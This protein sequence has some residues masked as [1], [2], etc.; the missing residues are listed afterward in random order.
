MTPRKNASKRPRARHW[1]WRLT[2]ALLQ[3]GLVLGLMGALV[4]SVMFWHLS[5]DLP[6]IAEVKEYRPPETTRILDRND[7]LLG[8]V[9]MERRTVV[10]MKSIPRVLVL[11]VLAAE[12]ADFYRHKGLDYPGIARAVGRDILEG[13][14]AQGASTITQQVVKL[15]LLS[16]ERTM[17][18]KVKELIL[19]R[20]LEQAL[21]KDEILYLYLNQINFGH[22]RYGVEEASRYYFGKHAAELTLAEASLIAGIPQSPAN[23]SPRKHPE[24]AR[25]RQ[26]FVLRQLEQKRDT[27]W[28]DLSAADIQT[29]RDTKVALAQRDPEAE[30]APEIVTYVRQFLKTLVG[31]QAFAQGGYTVHTSVDVE[32]QGAARRSLQRNLRDVDARHGYRLP[33][34]TPS[35]KSGAWKVKLKQVPTL[36][37]GGTYDAVVTSTDDATGVVHLD[38]GGHPSTL[39]ISDLARYNPEKLA[40][41]KGFPVGARLRVSVLTLDG[42]GT[43]ATVHAELG[44]EGA[45]V[46]I[47]PRNRDVLAVVGGYASETGW[48]R[49]MQAARQPGSTFKPI[50]YA[51]G[52]KKRLYTAASILVDAPAVYDQWAPQ[53]YET[54]NN[55]GA[56]RLRE[57]IAQSINL[58]AVRVIEALTP[59]EV[60]TFAKKLGISTPLDPSLPLAL[61]ASEVHPMELVNAYAVFA[62]GGRYA[63]PTI[64]TAIEDGDGKSVKLPPAAATRTVMTEAESYIVTS[65]LTSVIR[66]GTGAAAQKLGR[67]AAGKT[68][69][70][71][72]ARDAWF[73]G[74]TP[75][76]V[77]GVWVGFDDHRP[78]GKRESG[79]KA[80]V[81]IWVEVMSKAEDKKPVL[82]FPMPSGVVTARID[83][84]T[85]ALALDKTPNALDEVFLD[86]TAPTTTAANP[87]LVDDKTFLMEQLGGGA[88]PTAANP[89][90]NKAPTG[91][92]PAPTS[93]PAV[94]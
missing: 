87:D 25:K 12:D 16:P 15:L 40:P 4:A 61:G 89:T 73:V 6:T 32:L 64:I 34:D 3:I 72:G 37:V 62:S 47:D 55:A 85:G 22:G 83:P 46:V 58:V 28:P 59:A 23:L 74:Y 77:A 53:N 67:P 36:R 71:N 86:G 48:N 90:E 18:R 84:A 43:G 93:P 66:E 91:A 41:S 11:S 26:L 31:D 1:A 20:R 13:R 56:V 9:F 2:L 30:T 5:R 14:P 88:A 8:E 27:H 45:V 7:K 24:A 70:S 50:V 79:G 39:G 68:G 78:L 51:L 33:L 57:A 42:E 82:E 52:I 19:A 65:L 21:S 76:T 17:R 75:N 29:A 94:P 80:A 35:S 81:P 10:P 49:G 63:Q 69:T 38:V 44:P 60:V 92:E 54:W